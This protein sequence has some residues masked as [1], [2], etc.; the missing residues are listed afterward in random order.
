M[1]LAITLD[2]WRD[3]V[4]LDI[5]AIPAG[6]VTYSVER[7]SPS[8]YVVG[9]RGAIGQPVTGTTA[10]V[11]DY[12]LPLDTPLLYF[13][14]AYDAS[15]NV[16]D[17]IEAPFTLVYGKCEAWLV[18]LAQPTNSLRV[19]IESMTTL[20]YEL[21]V[22]VHRILDRRA[23]ILTTLPAWTP[24]TELLL[25][26]ETL[27]ERDR[28]RAIY[29][30]GYPFLLRTVPEQGVG[31]IYF[32]LTDFKEERL[33]SLGDAPLRRFTAECVQVER[34]DATLFVPR[35]PNTYQAVLDE[36]ADYEALLVF[37]YDGLLYHVPEGSG[38]TAL[39]P[40][41]PSDV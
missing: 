16:L 32:G 2:T 34:P 27:D 38:A 39:V 20:D 35:P 12:E 1:N 37:T 24:D 33:I 40:W 4:R 26:T 29:G 21:P 3:N 8:G 31:N 28:V 5:A 11:R 19:T 7:R 36:F 23:P 41:L 17:S 25:L 6:A 14:T 30:S 9:V 22:G 18:D 15:G 10:I 13:V